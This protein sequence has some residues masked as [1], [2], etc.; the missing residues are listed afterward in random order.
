MQIKIYPPPPSN[1]AKK[2]GNVP[3]LIHWPLEV[4]FA[5]V[6]LYNVINIKNTFMSSA[7]EEDTKYKIT[8]SGFLY[9]NIVLKNFISNLRVQQFFKK[10]CI[11][12]F[13]PM[14][15]SPSQHPECIT[16]QLLPEN[17]PFPEETGNPTAQ[18]SL[19]QFTIVSS[20]KKVFGKKG[21]KILKHFIIIC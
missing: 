1:Y 17:C 19:F 12:T 5:R 14:Y 3:I 18:D 16:I 13:Y 10:S 7:T 4:H 15:K 20:Y 8:A 21:N 9:S 6:Y 2:L 11:L